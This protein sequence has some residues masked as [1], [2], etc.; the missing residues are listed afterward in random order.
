MIIRCV[1]GNQQIEDKKIKMMCA[2]YSISKFSKKSLLWKNFATYKT[3]NLIMD[4][5]H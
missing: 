1:I 2:I 4:M 5:I 3:Q